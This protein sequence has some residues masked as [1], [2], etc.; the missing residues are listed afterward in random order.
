[1]Y[2]GPINSH[3][4]FTIANVRPNERLTLNTHDCCQDNP[5]FVAVEIAIPYEVLPSRCIAM[6]FTCV[7]S[8]K[9]ALTNFTLGILLQ[10]E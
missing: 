1:M 10:G 4:S 7:I 6:G 9:Y 2:A 3:M 8:A 5:I